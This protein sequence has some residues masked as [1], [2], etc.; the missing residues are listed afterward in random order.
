MAGAT[1]LYFVEGLEIEDYYEDS[2]EILLFDSVDEFRSIVRKMIENPSLGLEIGRSAQQRT[3]RDHT[4]AERAKKNTSA[5]ASH[6]SVRSGEPS[7]GNI[8]EYNSVRQK[9]GPLPDNSDIEQLCWFY[10]FEKI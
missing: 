6:L 5:N 4:Y 2:R 7:D 1:Q 8:C 9:S 10:I 3:L